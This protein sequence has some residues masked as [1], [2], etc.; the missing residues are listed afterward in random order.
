MANFTQKRRPRVVIW[1]LSLIIWSSTADNFFIVSIFKTCS[2]KS[3]SGDTKR[4]STLTF[5][6]C[7]RQPDMDMDT[8]MGTDSGPTFKVLRVLLCLG[9]RTWW[10]P[11]RWRPRPRSRHT[12]SWVDKRAKRTRRDRFIIKKEIFRVYT[13]GPALRFG[14]KNQGLVL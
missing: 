8:V 12:I 6:F 14:L 13:N 1:N 11:T 7:P 3:I 9:L 2:V 5:V 10:A 4:L